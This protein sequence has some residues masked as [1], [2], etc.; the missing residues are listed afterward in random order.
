MCCKYE[1]SDPKVVLSVDGV[2]ELYL[3][4]AQLQP[5]VTY[6]II[7]LCL[8]IIDIFIM[9]M[10]GYYSYGDVAILCSLMIYM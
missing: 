1:Y 8:K 5:S 7:L 10:I 4:M 3:H 9:T 6:L 2:M